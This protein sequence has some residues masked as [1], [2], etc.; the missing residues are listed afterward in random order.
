[1][2]FVIQSCSFNKAFCMDILSTLVGKQVNVI[3][4][5]LSVCLSAWISCPSLVGK[6]V[7]VIL[8]CLPACLPVLLCLHGHPSLKGKPVGPIRLSVC[9]SVCL[10]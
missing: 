7:N 6:Q 3:L 5:C 1:M 4:L 8:L 10:H 9:R 2:R